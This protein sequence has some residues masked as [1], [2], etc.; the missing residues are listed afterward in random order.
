MDGTLVMPGGRREPVTVLLGPPSGS[1]DGL[2]RA[3]RSATLALTLRHPGLVRLMQVVGHEDRVAWCYEFADG[4]GLSHAVNRDDGGG[5][6]ARAAA[7]IVAQ[8]AEVLLAVG[9]PGL[10]HPGPEPVDLLAEPDGHIRL[11]G[12]A[13]PYPP[14]PAMRPPKADAVEPGAA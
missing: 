3:R 11:T 5:L 4:L 10:H 14:D 6:A 12:F 8:V 1:A 13:G 2:M 7:E 9:G